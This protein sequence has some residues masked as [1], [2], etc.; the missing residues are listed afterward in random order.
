MGGINLYQYA[1]NTLSWI[2]PWGLKCS[3]EQLAK[4]RRNGKKAEDY[5]YWKQL[6]D[7]DV[8]V[9]GRQVYVKVEGEGPGGRY[10]DILIQNKKTGELTAIKDK[11]NGAMRSPP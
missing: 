9:L 7:P 10:I 2:D 4:N 5:I 3:P 1:P 11:Y 8:K 6:Q